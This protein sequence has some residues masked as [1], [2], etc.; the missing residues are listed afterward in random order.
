MY[1]FATVRLDKLPEKRR[2]W[3]QELFDRGYPTVYLSD[4]IGRSR[5]I[6]VR[7]VIRG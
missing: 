5:Q 1:S 4:Y 6:R 2:A 7:E 3:V